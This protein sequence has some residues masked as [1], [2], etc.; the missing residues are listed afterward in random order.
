M[1]F[2]EPPRY[3]VLRGTAKEVPVMTGPDDKAAAGRGHM[4]AA[5]ADREQVIA[6]LKAAFVQGRLTK[7]ELEA[8]AARTFAAKTYAELAELTADIPAS[9]ADP[10]WLPAPAAAGTPARTLG[11][12]ARRAGVC[13]LVALALTEGAF[14]AN[15]PIL[16]VLAFFAFIAASGFIG[17]GII[18]ARQQ[19][20]SRSQPPSPP[21]HDGGGPRDGRRA[22]P[23]PDPALPDPALPDPAR[24]DHT[25]TD[26]R[27]HRTRAS[28]PRH[29]PRYSNA[30]RGVF[31]HRGVYWILRCTNRSPKPQSSPMRAPP[32]TAFTTRV[33]VDR[34]LVQNE[35]AVHD[36]VL[37][38]A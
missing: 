18:D 12:A 23:G 38:R 16:L 25:R 27:A 6:V 33:T 14:L 30:Y 2:C 34:Y 28:H 19:W 37:R 35:V 9:P 4:R 31:G 20:R 24:P 21:G 3:A 17:Y 13:L 11:R 7:D 15:V 1:A 22:R 8:R 36:D 32:V 26:L 29:P 10:A 5:H